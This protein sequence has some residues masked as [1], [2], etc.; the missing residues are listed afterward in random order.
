M[1]ALL[2]LV[3]LL[4][5]CA[6]V[7]QAAVPL[8]SSA[9]L[10]Y[11]SEFQ[12]HYGQPISQ[13]SLLLR[14]AKAAGSNSV[15]IVPTSYWMDDAAKAFKSGACYPD[16]WAR[17]SK[18]DYLCSKWEWDSKCMPWTPE[19]IAN[20]TKGI[21]DCIKEAHDLFDEVLI[22]PHLDDAT[23]SM[24]WRNTLTFDPLKKDRYGYS[25]FDTMIN[26]ILKA[27][28]EV[29]KTSAKTFTFALV[30]EMG[31]T[32]FYAPESYQA[33][34]DRIRSEYKGPAQVETAILLNHGYLA[35]VIN[36]G[37]DPV[38]ERAGP[39]SK[40]QAY[41]GWGPLKPFDEWPEANRLNGSLAAIKGLLSSV[42]V[43]GVSCYPRTYADIKAS[44]LESCAV[45]FDG[46]LNAMGFDLKEW[47]KEPGKRFI[48][49]EFGIG[50]GIDRCGKTP[51]TSRAQAGL[52]S[53]LGTGYPWTQA[54]DPWSKAELRQY[55][56]DWHNSALDLLRAEGLSYHVTGAYLW[57]IVSHDP[58]G[59]HPATSTDKGS[60]KDEVIADAIKSYN[61][62][63][64][65]GRRSVLS[66]SQSGAVPRG[67]HQ[68]MTMMA[69]ALVIMAFDLQARIANF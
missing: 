13:C 56:R 61:L 44:N 17:Q 28:K 66:S 12:P 25:Y 15:N 69:C 53:H 35:G 26:P 8:S 10:F 41:Q 24:H 27:V 48:F 20:M 68:T 60:F 63:I 22:S 30:G 34:V 64:K 58:Q 23:N 45:K 55:R 51:A 19:A 52:Y 11:L 4:A 16:N 2:L 6:S 50:G 39:P 54:T 36:R 43:L 59:I 1:P 3:L 14:N 38:N 9:L 33:I 29:Y 40:L 42:D 37:P 57:S 47:Q 46:E 7:T 5:L 67:Q 32:I 49:S 18:I 31:A 21:K 62:G 65:G